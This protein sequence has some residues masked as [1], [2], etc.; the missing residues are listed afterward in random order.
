MDNGILRIGEWLSIPESEIQYEYCRSSGPGGQHVNTTDSAV[1]LRF[2]IIH[3]PSLPEEIRVRLLSLCGNMVNEA[4]ILDLFSQKFR[5]QLRNKFDV[6]EKLIVL[7]LKAATPPRKRIKTKPT[8]ASVE[9]RLET[10]AKHSQRKA[11]R[12][13]SHHIDD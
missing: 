12:R 8:K 9:R 11:E 4:G 6:R 13:N 10:K 7:L 3:S 2:D 1:H 5:H